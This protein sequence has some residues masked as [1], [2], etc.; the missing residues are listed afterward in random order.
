MR[1]FSA[2]LKQT[3]AGL[4][5]L[6]VMTVLLGLVYPLAIWG[7]GQIPGLRANANGSIVTVDG[8]AVG[9][10]LIGV[11][12]VDPNA[13]DDPANDRYFHNRPSAGAQDVLGPGDPSSSGPSNLAADNPKLVEAVKKRQEAI[14]QR[15]GVP[16]AQVPADA[17][18]ASGSGLDPDISPAYAQL[19]L[20]RVAKV[21]HLTESQVAQIVAENTKGRGA[22][23][24]GQ[25][26]VNV[27]A[28]NLAVKA[29]RH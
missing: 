21:N 29:A 28:L 3:A 12:P 23:F 6:L 8:Q 5:L 4:R 18:T 22:G 20:K 19:Q 11:D 25:P 13:K 17:V 10:S 7:I 26:T 16:V 15:E 1:W 24:V 9:S 27:L 14:A 2:V